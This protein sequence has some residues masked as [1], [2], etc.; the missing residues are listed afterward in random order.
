MSPAIKT[1]SFLPVT[2]PTIDIPLR[3][4]DIEPC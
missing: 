1:P 3:P 2:V 4:P